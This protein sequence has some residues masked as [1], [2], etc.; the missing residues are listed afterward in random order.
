M[1]WVVFLFSVRITLAP[2]TDRNHPITEQ[3][4]SCF[5]A[6]IPSALFRAELGWVAYRVIGLAIGVVVRRGQRA[7]RIGR[8][9]V[10]VRPD[11]YGVNGM[12][13]SGRCGMAEIR[14]GR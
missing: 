2:A 5:P 12:E 13:I 10:A 4:L 8:I 1:S 14:R 3:L 9:G 6:V 7:R 11:R